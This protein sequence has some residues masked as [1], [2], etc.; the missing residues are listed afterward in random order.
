[1]AC[2]E[3]YKHLIVT[4]GGQTPADPWE[5]YA[6]PL[7]YDAWYDVAKEIAREVFRRWHWLLSIEEK[8]KK[9]EDPQPSTPYP[10]RDQLTFMLREYNDKLDGLSHVLVDLVDV[11][12]WTWQ[13][14]IGRAIAVARDGTCVL[15][16]LDE[17]TAYYERPPAP[18]TNPGRRPG[19][20]T[21]NDEEPASTSGGWGS[22]LVTGG[23]IVGAIA[24]VR[25]KRKQKRSV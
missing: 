9:A 21:P 16:M 10:K 4:K 17:A 11:T 2:G 20:G 8:L 3:R 7:D 15:E 14:A 24:L 23:L 25:H 13:P 6:G 12:E 1:M 19:S 5:W 18:T 22:V